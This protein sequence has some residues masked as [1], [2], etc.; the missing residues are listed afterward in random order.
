MGEVLPSVERVAFCLCL[1]QSSTQHGLPMASVIPP[2]FFYLGLW[3]HPCTTS[4][5]SLCAASVLGAAPAS[6]PGWAEVIQQLNKT[7]LAQLANSPV[8]HLQP[9][10]K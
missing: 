2:S 6:S 1:P 7:E 3:H 4:T 9:H 8:P 10:K 5:K